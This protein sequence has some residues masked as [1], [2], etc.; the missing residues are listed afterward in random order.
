MKLFSEAVNANPAENNNEKINVYDQEVPAKD[1]EDFE[2]DV[3]EKI[4]AKAKE[5]G[6]SKKELGNLNNNYDK[7]NKEIKRKGE[8]IKNNKLAKFGYGEFYGIN[9]EYLKENTEEEAD[10]LKLSKE[11]FAEIIKIIE[12]SNF[13][14]NIESK[15][16]ELKISKDVFYKLAGFDLKKW[17]EHSNDLPMRGEFEEDKS[18]TYHNLDEIQK[19]KNTKDLKEKKL[20]KFEKFMKSIS[21]HKKTIAFGE[22]SLYLSSYG[23]PALNFLVDNDVKVEI[24]GHKISLK[25]LADNP[26][27][28]KEMDE[29]QSN[30]TIDILEKY[31]YPKILKDSGTQF[32]LEINRWNEETVHFG[33]YTLRDENFDKLKGDLERIGVSLEK[34]E[35][36]ALNDFLENKEQIIKFISD[37]LEISEKKV[38]NY[39]DSFYV[40]DTSKISIVDFD[41]FQ[42]NKNL[43]SSNFEFEN[44][45]QMELDGFTEEDFESADDFE[46]LFLELLE[47]EDYTLEK[48]KEIAED[49]PEEII[50]IISEV[51]GKNVEYD[52][53]R[54]KGKINSQTP[55]STLKNEKGI[56]CDYAKTLAFAKH[57]LTEKD[58]SN[59][60]KFVV[61]TTN[62]PEMDHEWNILVTINSDEN[63]VISFIDPTYH[64]S[65]KKL[66]AVDETHYYKRMEKSAIK[67]I[68]KALKNF[69]LQEKLKEILTEYDPKHKSEIEVNKKAFE[70]ITKKKRSPS[71]ESKKRVD[72]LP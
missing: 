15:S 56:C 5:F 71:R 42:I 38:R 28:T 39:V 11:N 64:D 25:D 55:H 65:G 4:Y 49:N 61:L 47:K 50:K 6:I 57:V 10:R 63:L 1:V 21:K 45:K 30:T 27:F 20:S 17:K 37:D 9:L 34:G 46:E 26:E 53:G 58:V 22:L 8:E 13:E 16:E 31:S 62:S 19:D 12:E 3:V 54:A 7:L 67:S 14:K 23:T 69:A 43:D 70:K 44:L 35:G 52:E 36:V 60:D 24:K 72:A 40:I 41:D 48:L 66:N 51:I 2:K 18:W 29:S 32:H 59:L 68:Q 33:D